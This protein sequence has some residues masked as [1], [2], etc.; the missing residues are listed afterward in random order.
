M[1]TSIIITKSRKNQ[2]A[3]KNA[4]KLVSFQSEDY[5]III[6]PYFDTGGQ[7]ESGFTFYR[8]Q[9]KVHFVILRSFKEMHHLIELD[10]KRTNYFSLRIR[11]KRFLYGLP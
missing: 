8:D 9:R 6:I 7:H 10:N 2:S 11:Q 4:L 3:I 1:N 5:F